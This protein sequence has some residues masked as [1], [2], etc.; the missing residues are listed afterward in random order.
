MKN[1]SSNKTS[2]PD[3]YTGEFFKIFKE[4]MSDTPKLFQKTPK[5]K[6]FPMC[7]MQQ[8][9]LLIPKSDS[10]YKKR[11]SQVNLCYKTQNQKSEKFSDIKIITHDNKDVFVLLTGIYYQR[12]SEFNLLHKQQQKTHMITLIKTSHLINSTLTHDFF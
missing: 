12:I 2:G 5:R 9:Q 11:K 10:D 3:S 6:C 1:I 4:I 7:S 8:A